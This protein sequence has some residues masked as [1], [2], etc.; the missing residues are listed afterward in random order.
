VAQD[1][2]RPEFRRAP[3]NGPETFRI[4][5]SVNF[6]SQKKFGEKMTVMNIQEAWFPATVTVTRCLAK[7]SF[8]CPF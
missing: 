7:N 3:H 6:I 5:V 8:P 4:I 2:P 1:L